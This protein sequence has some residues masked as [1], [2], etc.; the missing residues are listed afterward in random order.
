MVQKEK[1]SSPNLLPAEFAE[2]GKKR[3]VEDFVNAQTE[4]V[5]K[6]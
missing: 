3:R 6:L 2:M 4:L 5:E 1:S